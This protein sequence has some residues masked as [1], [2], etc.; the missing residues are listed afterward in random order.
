MNVQVDEEV[1]VKVDLDHDGD[2]LFSCPNDGCIKTS[3][4]H[5]ALE[6]HIFYGCEF[7]PVEETLMNQAKALYYEKLQSDASAPP[8][9]L[10]GMPL[11]RFTTTEALLEGWAL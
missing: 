7:R 1:S 8:P 4:R 11:P 10:E 6:N 5:A 9:S 3:M 2:S